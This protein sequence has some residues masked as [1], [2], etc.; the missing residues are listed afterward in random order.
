MRDF[1]FISA[2]YGLL[3]PRSKDFKALFD[4]I[5]GR[6]GDARERVLLLGIIQ[7]LWDRME[8]SGWLPY[9]TENPLPGNV[10]HQVII[11]YALGDAQVS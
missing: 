2:P 7:L 9:L 6:Y 4:V 1:L 5:S 8:P 11:H 10:A 3:L